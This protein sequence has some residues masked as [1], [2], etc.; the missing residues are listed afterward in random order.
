MLVMKVMLYIVLGFVAIAIAALLITGGRAPDSGPVTLFLF[1]TLFAVAPLGS[2]WMMYVSIRYEKK[3]LPMILLAAF[4]PFAF[5]W[6]YFERIR[7]G[8]VKRDREFAS[9]P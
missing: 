3:P 4:V 6:Y 8:R 9:Q 7:P 1:I 2:F 5:L